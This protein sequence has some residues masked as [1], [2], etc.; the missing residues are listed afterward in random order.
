MLDYDASQNHCH[1]SIA[2][3][4][5]SEHINRIALSPP[6]RAFFVGL[7]GFWRD[8]VMVRA[9]MLSSDGLEEVC[10]VM[11]AGVEI[12]MMKGGVRQDVVSEYYL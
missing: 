2:P 8:E 10:I 1:K 6:I 12:S 5:F 7:E 9:M 3:R 11:R 4:N